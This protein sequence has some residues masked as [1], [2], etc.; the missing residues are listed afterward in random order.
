MF[1]LAIRSAMSGEVALSAHTSRVGLSGGLAVHEVRRL[2][3]MRVNALPYEVVLY[4]HQEELY[5]RMK[6]FDDD[7]MPAVSDDR[8][9]LELLELEYIQTALGNEERRTWME[10]IELDGLKILEA[11]EHIK[12]EERVH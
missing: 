10:T 12:N 5:P 7:G 3:A 2:L 6:L 8:R 1:S 4:F 11:P 9:I